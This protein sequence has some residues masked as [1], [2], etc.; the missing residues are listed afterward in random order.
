M[1]EE[2]NGTVVNTKLLDAIAVNIK[3]EIENDLLE[4][5]HHIGILYLVEIKEEILKADSDGLDSEGAAWYLI[6]Q[7]TQEE[8]SPFAWYGLKM[9]NFK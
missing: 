2:I 5:L 3:W 7:L 4:D 8:L 6:D 9:L 1:L